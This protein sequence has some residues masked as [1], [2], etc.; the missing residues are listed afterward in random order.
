M[1]WVSTCVS[2]YDVRQSSY[3]ARGSMWFHVRVVE[4]LVPP[5]LSGGFFFK[6]FIPVLF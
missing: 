3:N 4:M 5:M 1:S 6:I 2:S